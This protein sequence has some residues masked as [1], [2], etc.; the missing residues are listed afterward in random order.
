[1][2]TRERAQSIADKVLSLSTAD[3]LQLELSEREVTHLRFARNAPTTSGSYIE[4]ALTVRSSFGTRTGSVTANQFDDASLAAAVARA[5][6]LARLA[7]ED[8]EHMPVLGPQEYP[9]TPAFDSATAE[10]GAEGLFEGVA[11]NL[12]QAARAGVEAAGFTET[13]AEARAVASSRGL[14]GYSRATSAYLSETA[15]LPDG[16]GSGWS[17]AVDHRVGALDFAGVSR[18]AI[19]KAKASKAPRPLPPGEYPTILEPAC[20]ANLVQML[21]WMLDTRAADEGRS[22]FAAGEGGNRRGEAL[23]P[24]DIHIYSDPADALAP[25]APWGEG[26]MPQ[27][28]RTWIEN[29]TL[30]NLHSDRYW[31]GKQNIEAIPPPANIIMRGGKGS[32]ADLIA[33][34]E[35]GVLVTSLWY[36]RGVDPRSLLFTGLTRDGVFLIEDGA[37]VHPVQNFRWNESIIHVLK[38]VEAM[39]ESVRVSPRPQ[40]SN[41]IVVPA[42][43]LSSFHFTSVSEAV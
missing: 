3:E 39:S 34:T 26:G 32:V 31:A 24:G 23:F 22:Y 10:R 40:R 2:I 15:R 13:V 14:F 7:P 8:P 25:A 42:L 12:E 11:G 6:E 17:S 16:S 35:R 4:P 38:S 20:V 19:A 30:A 9:E 27:A 28:P 36:V 37:I 21:A 29:G 43:K 33:A 5:E 18:T 41:N 1:M